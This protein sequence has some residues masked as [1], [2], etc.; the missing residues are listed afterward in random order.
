MARSGLRKSILLTTASIRVGTASLA[1]EDYF[2]EKLA[3]VVAT[4]KRTKEELEKRGFDVLDSQTNFLFARKEGVPGQ[5]IFE[6]L[7]S[8]N[9]FVRHFNGE[10]IKDYLRITVGTDEQ[11][12]ALLAALDKI[13]VAPIL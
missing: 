10:R 11:M 4:R 1:D 9:I 2:R 12:D 3:Q 7:R 8:E 13:L 5:E 6:K